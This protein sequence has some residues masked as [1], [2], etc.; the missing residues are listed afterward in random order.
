MRILDRAPKWF[1]Q[2]LFAV[3]SAMALGG[4]GLNITISNDSTKDIVLTVYDLNTDP[5]KRVV[6]SQTINGFASVSVSIV[7]NGVGVGHLSW[8]A[9]TS[10]PDTRTC[11]H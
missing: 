10:D 1:V 11:G 7:A 6:S 4:D 3:A 5:V 2:G 8:T 9:V